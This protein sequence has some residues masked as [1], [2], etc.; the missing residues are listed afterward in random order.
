MT[1][2][3]FKF[4]ALNSSIFIMKGGLG[5]GLGERKKERKKERKVIILT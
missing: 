1:K 3:L 5:L 4:T 2:D